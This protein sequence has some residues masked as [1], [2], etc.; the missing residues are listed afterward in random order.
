VIVA[1]SGIR[2]IDP[3]MEAE[4]DMAMMDVV[5]EM[6]GDGA[7]EIRF[8]GALG[9]D[10]MALEAVRNQPPA[11]LIRDEGGSR[12]VSTIRKI[13]IT[14]FT[15]RDMS[16]RA[17]N[18]AVECSNH[19][20]EMRLPKTKRA[21]L[22]RNEALLN[23]A[24]RLVAF[25]DGRRTGGTA[26]TI[27][28]AEALRIPTRI[29]AVRSLE[30]LVSNP[31]IEDPSLTAPTYTFDYYQRGKPLTRLIKANKVGN[32]DPAAIEK[33]AETLARYIRRVPTLR[34]AVAIVPMPRRS[35]GVPSDMTH[36]TDLIA[37]HCGFSRMPELE[38]I[39][40]PHGGTLIAYRMRHDA[41]QHAA[42]MRY[43][44]RRGRTIGRVIVLDNVIT[45]GGSMQGAYLA[46]RRDGGDPVGLGILLS[47]AV[48]LGE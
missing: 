21:Y 28:R 2:A 40:A 43:K 34:E 45:T 9:L 3:I 33:L 6:D 48:G 38:R 39:A 29:V 24:D 47:H 13:V 12:L 36:L 10:T 25:T 5:S 23:G 46:I 22:D 15:V 31:R 7:D 27:R 37:E 16:L 19:I 20:V 42:T 8:G 11:R 14:P 26:W 1:I 4:V 32:A 44:H 17:R 30:E 41:D 35:P 18:V